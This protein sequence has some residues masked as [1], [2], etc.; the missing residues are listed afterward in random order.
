MRL[1]TE[2]DVQDVSE[3]KKV[4]REMLEKSLHTSPGAPSLTVLFDLRNAS[5]DKAAMLKDVLKNFF[6]SEIKELSERC[7]SECFVVISQPAIALVVQ[8]VVKACGG[9]IKTT[10][11]SNDF[12]EHNPKP[13]SNVFFFLYQKSAIG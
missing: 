5:A 11:T 1:T 4:Y 2:Q 9:T 12:A 10:I 13:M 7:I 6:G 3:F 8:L